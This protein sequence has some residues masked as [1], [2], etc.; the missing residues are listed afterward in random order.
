MDER[1]SPPEGRRSFLVLDRIL[2]AIRSGEYRAGACLPTERD[3]TDICGVSRS[4]VW[5]AL[6]I[7]TRL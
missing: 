7:L 5:E 1:L 3:L 6:S 2:Q 4:S